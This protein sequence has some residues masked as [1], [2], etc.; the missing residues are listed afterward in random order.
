MQI[1]SLD[2]LSTEKEIKLFGKTTA[3]KFL[4]MKIFFIGLK[5]VL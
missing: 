5:S 3:Q 4:G 2:E 1:Q